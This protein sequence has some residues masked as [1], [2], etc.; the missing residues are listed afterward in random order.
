MRP[1]RETVGPNDPLARAWEQ[2]DT[3]GVREIAVVEDGA[4]V[5]IVTRSDLNPHLGYLEFTPVR[6]A[7]TPAPRTVPADAPAGT[8][9]REL[10]A[11]GFNAMPVVDGGALAG[12]ITRQ[13]LLR[14]LVEGPGDVRR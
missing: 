12:M 2:M 8:I 4:L 6:L 11:G 1:T 5:G 10:L 3:F 7:M 14:V 9:A 13:D